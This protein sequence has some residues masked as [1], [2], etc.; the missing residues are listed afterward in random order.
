MLEGINTTRLEEIAQD[1]FNKAHKYPRWQ[2]A[3]MKAVNILENNPY[4]SFDGD[5]LLI[6]SDS[7]EIYKANGTCQ[8]KAFKFGKPCAHR[9]TARLVERYFGARF[10]RK[11]N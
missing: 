6:L 1:A 11:G 4:V 7:G 9:A 3:I 5:S 8:C 2:V 10:V